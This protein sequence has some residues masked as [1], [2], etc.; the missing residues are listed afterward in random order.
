[1]KAGIEVDVQSEGKNRLGYEDGGYEDTQE[2]DILPLE[3]NFLS[4]PSVVKLSG[5][6]TLDAKGD[7]KNADLAF[8]R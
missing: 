2:V 5:G 4:A 7:G 6:H 1:M 3:F 8:A